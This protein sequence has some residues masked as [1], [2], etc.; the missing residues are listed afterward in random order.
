ME[1]HWA[2]NEFGA[3]RLGDPRRTRRLVNIALARGLRPSTSLPQCFDSEAELDAMY[4]FCSNPHVAPEAI[5]A[6][7]YQATA[8]RLAGHRV[9]LVAQDSSYVDYTHHPA[10]QGLG[11]LHDDKHQGFL[12]HSSLA[13]TP[14]RVPLGL[15]DQQIIYRDRADYGKKHQRKQR[16]IEA[17]ESYKWLV[18]LKSTAA[19]QAA[20]PDT[21][22]VN[23]GDREADVYDVFACAATLQQAVLV[24]AAWNRAVEHNEK[25]LWDWIDTCKVAG[26]VVVHVPRQAGQPA[27]KARLSLRHGQVSLKPPCHRKAEK[28]PAIPVYAVLGREEHPPAGQTAIE[29]L[30]LTTVPANDFTSAAERL[31]WYSCR[32]VIEIYHKVLK[33]GCKIEERQFEAAERLERYLAV[34]SVVAWRI[35][36][37]TFQCRQ[38]P[39][40]SCEAFLEP[41]EWQALFCYIHKTPT[42]PQQPPTLKQVARW[43]AKLGGFLGRKGDGDPGVTVMWRGLQQLSDIVVMWRVFNPAEGRVI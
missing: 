39:E 7:H 30:L 23:M 43:V 20:H 11:I 36:G 37:L 8:R 41:E 12:L 1:S 38:T 16:P 4:D 13:L 35:L 21:L 34:D 2:E 29:W 26:H 10:T 31:E 22:L 3:A 18:S 40:M 6:S 27:R 25:Y 33:S 24:R 15:L 32:W 19:V 28:L 9:V 14:S 42:A 5:L 17:K